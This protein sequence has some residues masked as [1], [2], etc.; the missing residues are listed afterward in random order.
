[1]QILTYPLLL[2]LKLLLTGKLRLSRHER[3]KVGV[4]AGS[5]VK[6]LVVGTMVAVAA[7]VVVTVYIYNIY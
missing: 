6:M 2:H 4:V 3:K 7:V 5:L 1:M